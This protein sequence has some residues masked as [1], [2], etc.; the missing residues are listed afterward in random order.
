MIRKFI[1][2]WVF[3]LFFVS[4][5]LAE[6]TLPPIGLQWSPNTEADLAG[7]QLHWR[8]NNQTSSFNDINMHD[9]PIITAVSVL[10]SD[11]DPSKLT[12]YEDKIYALT[13][14]DT[15]DN[16]SDYSNEVLI[17][18]HGQVVPLTPG[19]LTIMAPNSN[20]TININPTPVQ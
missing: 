8:D 12:D 3:I 10:F 2:L 4:Y 18:P 20:I 19:P 16:V 14:K 1:C 11:I 13:A 17:L 7:Y 6:P 5:A 15:S 9:I